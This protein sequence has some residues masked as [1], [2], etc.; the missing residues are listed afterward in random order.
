MSAE[1]QG[2]AWDSVFSAPSAVPAENR[3]FRNGHHSRETFFFRLTESTF[4]VRETFFHRLPWR[5][6]APAKKGFWGVS[7]GCWVSKNAFLTVNNLCALPKIAFLTVRKPCEGRKK[8]FLTFR[9]VC[10]VSKKGFSTVNN[11]CALLK[12]A[13]LTVRKVCWVPKIPFFVILRPKSGFPGGKPIE[14]RS[15][16][17]NIRHL[18]RFQKSAQSAGLNGSQTQTKATRNCRFAI[19]FLPRPFPKGRGPG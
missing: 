14:T 19:L 13:F 16:F 1:V 18:S 4:F 12:I 10:W 8:P 6:C 3:S 15:H 11:P 9:K 2:I 5:V 17:P 7:K